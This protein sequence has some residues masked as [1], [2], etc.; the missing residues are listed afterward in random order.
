[1]VENVCKVELGNSL[2][3]TMVTSGKVGKIK[4]VITSFWRLHSKI[5]TATKMEW[6]LWLFIDIIF[7][8][9]MT[10]KIRDTTMMELILWPFMCIVFNNIMTVKS[11]SLLE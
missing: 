3:I 5:R 2:G 11:R 8:N 6:R 4:K 9:V 7:N 10:S 1:M